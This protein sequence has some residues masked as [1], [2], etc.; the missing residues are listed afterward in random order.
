MFDV[1]VR[2]SFSAAH[3]V[4]GHKGA[5]ANL[6]GHNWD[7][8]V[9]LRGETLDSTGF[10]IDFADVKKTVRDLAGMLDHSDLNEL[11]PF[12]EQNPTSE[13]LARFLF[14]ELSSRL[15]TP[16]HRVWCVRVSESPGSTASYWEE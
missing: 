8:E 11:Q 5:C 4:R 12:G 14:R 15:N 1:S 7:V 9:S 16:R 6:H 13:N 10:L 2:A 3:R